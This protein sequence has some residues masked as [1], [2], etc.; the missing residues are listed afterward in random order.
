MND[1][2]KSIQLVADV[3]AGET[4]RIGY[5]DPD[6]ILTESAQLQRKMKDFNPEAIYLYTCI[7]RRFFMQQDVNLE[8][9]PFNKIAPTAGV[10]TFGEFYSDSNFNALLNS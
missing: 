7:C 2:D 4:L 3:K 5:G 9:L 1:I 6:A 8:T 10:Y